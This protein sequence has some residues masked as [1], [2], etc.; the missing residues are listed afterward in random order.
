[1]ARRINHPVL[2]VV[3]TTFCTC[4]DKTDLIVWSLK[5]EILAR[6]D[7]CH[8]LTYCCKVIYWQLVCRSTVEIFCTCTVHILYRY[9]AGNVLDLP[10]V[11]QVSPCGRFVAT[12]G[13]TPDV[14]VI[15]H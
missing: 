9:S 15:S 11:L 2:A 14:K 5:G 13:F 12:S 4:S 8:N 7:T 3:Y 1:M 6:L 10:A